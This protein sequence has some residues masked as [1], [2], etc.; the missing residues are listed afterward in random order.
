[1]TQDIIRRLKNTGRNIKTHDRV[2]ELNK[3]MTKTK[4]S[5][6]SQEVSKDVLV[7]YFNKVRQELMGGELVNRSSR[8]DRTN[9]QRIKMMKLN[10]WFK[11]NKEHTDTIDTEEEVESRYKIKHQPSNN[12]DKRL[13]IRQIMR[14]IRK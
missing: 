12:N 10:N 4:R 7:G 6:Y 1:M 9:R 5:G 13:Q 3:Y 11:D 8:R 14:I 2:R